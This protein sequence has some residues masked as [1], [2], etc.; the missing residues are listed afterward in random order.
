MHIYS[1]EIVC[2]HNSRAVNYKELIIP[3]PWMLTVTTTLY[4]SHTLYI[5]V[6][7]YY[8][9]VYTLQILCIAGSG[10]VGLMHMYYTPTQDL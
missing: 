4:Y 2:G 6:S 7:L 1:A 10:L 8:E 3:K 9:E 5:I